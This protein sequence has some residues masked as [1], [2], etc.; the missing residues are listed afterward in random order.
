[1]IRH[2]SQNQIRP[3][4]IA[5]SANGHLAVNVPSGLAATNGAT[6]KNAHPAMI[7]HD[8]IPIAMNPAVTIR[9]VANP[10]RRLVHLRDPIANLRVV[11]EP[12]WST[13]STT[14]TTKMMT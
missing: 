5:R 12:G 10:T 9:C 1:M 13:I 2:R 6:A 3:H 8:V 7:G 11:S 14:R 4:W